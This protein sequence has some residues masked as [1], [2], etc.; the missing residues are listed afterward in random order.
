MAQVL[1]S[2]AVL[3]ES[4]ESSIYDIHQSTAWND[5]YRVDGLFGGDKRGISLAL[6][7]DGVNPQQSSLLNVAYHAHIVKST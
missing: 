5:A 4:D 7:T 3:R 2:H 1:Q 6:C